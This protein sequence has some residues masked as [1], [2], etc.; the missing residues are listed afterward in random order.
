MTILRGPIGAA[1]VKTSS[2]VTPKDSDSNN[3]KNLRKLFN[4]LTQVQN[5]SQSLK[6]KANVD[7]SKNNGLLD[8]LATK[9][10]K[11][12]GDAD[13]AEKKTIGGELKPWQKELVEQKETYARS[14][15]DRQAAETKEEARVTAALN[16]EAAE[17][18]KKKANEAERANRAPVTLKM[19]ANGIPLPPP[20]PGIHVSQKL[21]AS[22][23]EFKKIAVCDPRKRGADGTDGTTN[24][25][26]MA[27]LLDELAIKLA[28]RADVAGIEGEKPFEGELKPWQKELAEQKETYVRS[29]YDR[30]AAEAKEEAR[31]TAALNA[32]AAEKTKKKANEAERANRAP[33]ILKMDENGIPLPPPPPMSRFK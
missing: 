8:E 15:Y 18:A 16:A 14:V 13:I 19:D 5:N 17:K 23:N 30:E 2:P 31:V 4:N 1:V 33:V 32:E 11:R 29:A 6:S 22:I 7:C 24:K 27:N 3:G 25:P 12:A 21:F 10:A 28:K 20:P 26:L 9:L